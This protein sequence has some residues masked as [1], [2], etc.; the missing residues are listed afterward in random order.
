[1]AKNEASSWRE[2][3]TVR[4][5]V[6][7]L[8]I[9]AE[10]ESAGVTEIADRLECSKSSIHSQLSTLEAVGYLTRSG[11][12]YRLSNGLLLIGERI[13]SNTPIFRFGRK[14]AEALAAETDHYAHLYV[15]EDGLGVNIYDARGELASDYDYQ[16]L[17]LQHKEPL[18]ITAT[19]KAILAQKPDTEIR[20]IIE[21][22]GLER[23]TPHTIT[24]EQVL[25]DEL[26]TIRKCGFAVNDE[27]EIEGFRAV[28]APV[29]V[30]NGNIL[31]SIS[32]SAPKA[33]FDAER[34]ET[35]IP[36]LVTRAA[37]VIEV[38]YNMAH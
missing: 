28:A 10:T 17:K 7:I 16:S 9:L 37:N 12:S 30:D 15:E 34:F 20:D 27:E 11:T 36:K 35:T 19:G 23:H 3:Q 29:C 2:L 8:E 14:Q 22:H 1:M 6:E 31:G 32:V 21:E 18:H 33:Y 24:D 38:Q 26:E 13:R 25:L 5:A 4:T